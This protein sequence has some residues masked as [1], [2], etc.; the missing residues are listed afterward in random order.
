MDRKA[1]EV[2]QTLHANIDVR[3]KVSNLNHAERIAVEIAKVLVF[4]SKAIILDEPTSGLLE[5]EVA[6]LFN[7]IK[8]LK[9]MDISILYISNKVEEITQIADRIVVL[10]DGEIVDEQQ[11]AGQLSPNNIIEKMAG[12][13]FINRY[14]KT[15]ASKGGV[16]FK[17][18][19][20][21]SRDKYI[22]D[23]SFHIRAGEIVGLAG[24][25]GAGKT[26]VANLVCGVDKKDSGSI[27]IHGKEV[28]IRNPHQAVK[29]GVV[30]L[31]DSL[32]DNVFLPYNAT[33][34][35]SISN[36]RRV[37]RGLFIRPRLAR[38]LSRQYVHRLNLKVPYLK[39]TVESL[40]SGT[41]Q[42]LSLAKLLFS[43]SSIYIMDEPSKNLDI[44]S[45]VEWYNMMNKMAYNGMGILL[46]SSDISELVGMCD[47]ILVMFKGAIVKELNSC[48]AS[49][50][51]ILYYS[52]G[53]K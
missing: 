49:S 14:P 8:S 51:K 36:L 50:K 31:S 39:E 52:M 9:Q 45:K 44:P 46:I 27:F 18:T 30:Y 4:Q 25:Q 17:A 6:S 35:L 5:S 48:E 24:L 2:L 28:N 43:D 34:N 47:R 26:S 20:L 19:S 15:K 3:M 16:I 10:R 40:S 29:N 22:Y 12:K 38:V 33:F 42:K 41:L 7:I 11:S 23:I 32:T 37:T 13:D 1:A 21:R 53:N